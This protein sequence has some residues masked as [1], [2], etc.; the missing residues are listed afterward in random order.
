MQEEPSTST[1]VG[2]NN[3]SPPPPPAEKK[4]GELISPNL[5]SQ[6]WSITITDPVEMKSSLIHHFPKFKGLPG[7]DPNRH[8]QSFQHKMTSLRQGTE[9]RDRAMLQAFPFSL[10]DSTEEW[11]YYLPPGSI[12]TWTEM[13]KLFLEKYFI[14]SKA[15]VVRKE[16]SGVLQISGESLHEYWERY[17]KLLASCPH[18]NI[19]PTLIIQYFYEVLLPDQHNLINAAAGSSL[20]EKTL[21]QATSLIESMA[22]NAQQ[23]YTRHDS[24][25]R[26]LVKWR[27]LYNPLNG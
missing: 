26:R 8:L 7:E 12:T 23:F 16:I 9:D 19:S 14:A 25:I 5:D 21:S 27:T 22:T 10:Q 24:N 17:K 15:A 3:N 20:T 2:G 18:H 4:L 6:P 1:M 11:L 13:K